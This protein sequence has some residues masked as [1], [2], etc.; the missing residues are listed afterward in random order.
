MNPSILHKVWTSRTKRLGW[1]HYRVGY[2]PD[3]QSFNRLD[4]K[5]LFL[6]FKGLQR[7]LE[8]TLIICKVVCQ[9][10]NSNL[11]NPLP[12]LFTEP[13]FNC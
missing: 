5:Q 4:K 11:L 6:F 8:A 9:I 13:V 2:F 1:I 10:H 3:T 12:Y 7:W